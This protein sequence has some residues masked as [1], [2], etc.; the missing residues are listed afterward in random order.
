MPWSIEWLPR[1][2]VA[3]VVCFSFISVGSAQV[4]I[5]TVGVGNAGNAADAHGEGY[6]AVGYAYGIGKYEVTAGQYAAFLNAVAATD[7]YGLYNPD[8]WSSGFGCKI[9][10]SDSPGG[11]TY[12][13]ADDWASR[14][15]NYVSWADAARFANWLHNGRPGLDSPVA[16]N[17]N[18]TEDGAYLLNGAVTDEALMTITREA[19]WK[20]AIP[21]ED[22]WY[23][24]AYHKND[25]A[26]DNYWDF[27]AGSDSVPG[28]RLIDPDPGNNGTFCTTVYISDRGHRGDYTIGRPYYRTEVGAHENSDSPYGTFDQGGN[29]WEW[30]EATVTDMHRG[31]RGGSFSWMDLYLNGHTLALYAPSRGKFVPTYESDSIGFRVAAIPEPGV[32]TLLALGAAG[33]CR[34]RR[35]VS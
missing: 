33:I 9:Q 13:V 25:G 20:W 3:A 12:S 8:M 14:P 5:E 24:A 4:P 2:A 27:P 34:R 17:S 19:D 6:G 1:A 32:I 10:R 15:V 18:S 28:N 7:T 35:Y 26:T 22:E 11:Y 29:V 21:T 31:L 30:N 23:K 16:Q